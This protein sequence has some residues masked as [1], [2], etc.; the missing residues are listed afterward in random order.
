VR[1][2]P[3]EPAEWTD[4]VRDFFATLHGPAARETGAPLN[5]S[6]LLAR[7]PQMALALL[8]FGRKAKAATE[9]APRLREIVIMRVAW[10]TRT[11]YVWGPHQKDMLK[12]GMDA[13][14]IEGAR[15]GPAALVWTEAER[16]ALRAADELVRTYDVTDET[17]RALAASYSEKQV[18]DIL[19]V[20]GQYMVFALLFNVAG[21][22]LEDENAHLSMDYG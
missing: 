8:E 14:H 7:H 2:P 18:F 20:V 4:E 21:L 1:I 6:R 12:L 19:A 5:M 11:D 22:R 9:I 15:L 13:A 16:T 10:L 17:W 3:L